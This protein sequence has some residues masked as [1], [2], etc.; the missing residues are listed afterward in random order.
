VTRKASD[1]L[2]IPAGTIHSAKNV[3]SS[4]A[5]QLATYIVEQGK[6]LRI[7]VT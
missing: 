4:H 6:P 2:C 1:V 5:A 7:L 3:G